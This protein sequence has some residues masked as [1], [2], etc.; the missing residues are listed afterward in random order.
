MSLWKNLITHS[1][2]QKYLF[3]TCDEQSLP[4]AQFILTSFKIFS[5]LSVTKLLG[6]CFMYLL[7]CYHVRVL[8]PSSFGFTSSSPQILCN[9]CS[10]WNAYYFDLWPF[11]GANRVPDIIIP[12]SLIIFP[13][14]RQAARQSKS[15]FSALCWQV[16]AFPDYYRRY[17]GFS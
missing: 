12:Y 8:S 4:T 16:S 9:D 6:W 5:W 11:C 7:A 1:F 13:A 15:L 17:F 14:A 3:C 10:S 2:F